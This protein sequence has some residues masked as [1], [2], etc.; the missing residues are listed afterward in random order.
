MIEDN[1]QKSFSFTGTASEYFGIWIVNILLTI[2]TL[3]I[4]SAWAKVR[5]N[6][7]F[8]GHTHVAG[9]NF[10]YL[11]SP[12]TILKGYLIAVA[13]FIIYSAISYFAPGFEVIFFI[14]LMIALPFIIVRAMAFRLRNS[15]YRHLRFQFDRQYGQ[16][17]RIYLGIGILIPLTL[18]LI[19][20]YFYYRTNNFL[21]GNTGYGKSRFS[22]LCGAGD[23]YKIYL[24]AIGILIGAGIIV[25]ITIMPAMTEIAHMMEQA[26]QSGVEPD[27]IAMS[28][29]MVG[30]PMIMSLLMSLLYFGLFIYIR[31]AIANLVWNNITLDGG[32]KF[33]S[34]L[35]LGRMAWIFFSNL[36]AIAFSFGL[37]IPWGR[38]RMVRYRMQ[39]LELIPEGDLDQFIAAKTEETSALGEEMGDVFDMDIGGIG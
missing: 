14:M 15:A 17:A 10:D 21:I 31:T 28:A 30:L 36:V 27:P 24:I 39:T 38:V 33:N 6:R 8:Y 32:H 13:I 18:G 22:L 25:T 29:A 12:I 20:P 35:T 7:Y 5:T 3:G 19:L 34:S 16:A 4:Y 2:L 9:A 23:F 26:K 37:L 1:S 11:A